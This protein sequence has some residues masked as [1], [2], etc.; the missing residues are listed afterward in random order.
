MDK[1]AKDNDQVLCILKAPWNGGIAFPPLR[2]GLTDGQ[3]KLIKGVAS[4][5][6]KLAYCVLLNAIC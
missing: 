3:A 4:L 1:L 5:L 6:K 2:Y